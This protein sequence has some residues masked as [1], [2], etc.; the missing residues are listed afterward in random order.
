MGDMKRLYNAIPVKNYKSLGTVFETTSGLY[1]YDTGTGKVFSCNEV[2][3]NLFKIIF[4]GG[5][6]NEIYEKY[7]AQEINKSISEI[8]K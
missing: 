6:T 1:V 5:D 8:I 7:S 3:Y 4:S 2:T